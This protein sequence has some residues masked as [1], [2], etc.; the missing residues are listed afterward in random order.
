MN[1]PEL[2]LATASR[3][4]STLEIRGI[5]RGRHVEIRDPHALAHVAGQRAES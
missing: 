5:R 4:L 2:T 3:A 1:I